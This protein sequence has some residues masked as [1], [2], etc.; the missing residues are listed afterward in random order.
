MP[1]RVVGLGQ[2][3]DTR[4]L[5]RRFVWQIGAVVDLSWVHGELSPYY[6]PTGR[7][8]IQMLIVGYAFCYSIGA[9]DLPG[10]PG[11]SCVSLIFMRA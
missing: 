2:G 10:G 3:K 7:L 1:S 11:Q 6:S 9:P 5:C 4:C 8:M